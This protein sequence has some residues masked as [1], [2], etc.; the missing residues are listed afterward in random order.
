MPGRLEWVLLAYRIPREPSTPR[1]SVWRKLRRL[2][3]AQLGDGLVAL[4]NDARTKEQLEWIA[5]EVLEAGGEA[6][7]WI[8]WAGSAG[9]ERTLASTMAAAVAEEYQAV[10]DAADAAN[11]ESQSAQRRVAARLRRELHRL[12]Q[13]DHFPPPEREKAHRA[14]ERLRAGVEASR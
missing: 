1:I 10:I 8:A 9:Q 11:G 13:R 12:A 5:D 2:G 14:V 7:L 3:A 6:T 4:P